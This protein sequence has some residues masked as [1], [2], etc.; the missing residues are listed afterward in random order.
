[1]RSAPTCSG[2]STSSVSEPGAAVYHQR[3]HGRRSLHR[4]AQSL[5]HGGTT[6]ATT[7]RGLPGWTGLL[8]QIRLS[9]AAHSSGVREGV[10]VSRQWA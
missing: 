1:M 4:L 2:S 9:V 10:V 6:D 5:G 3:A 8:R 7:A